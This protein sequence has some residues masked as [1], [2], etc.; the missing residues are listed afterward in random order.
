MKSEEL[1]SFIKAI[2]DAVS[3]RR[4]DDDVALPVFDPATSDNGAETWCNNIA[5]LTEEF[6]WS[7]IATV[8]KAEY[9]F[10]SMSSSSILDIGEKVLFDDSIESIEFHPYTP[11][12]DSF[13]NNDNIHICINRQD[14]ILLP[15]QSQILVEGTVEKGCL[16]VNNGAAFL[17]QDIRYEL[18]GVEIDQAR[19][20]G[21]T[22]TMKG[23][24]SY[25]KEMDHSL[26]TAGWEVGAKKI[27]DKFT[28]T[29]P[30]SH[31]LGFAEDYKKVIMNGKHELI[32]NRASTDVNCL[33]L[34]AVDANTVP[35]PPVPNGE[36]E[37]TR[38]TW[39]MPVIKVS[40]KEKLRLMSYV[41][42]S[43]PVQIVPH[44]G[45]V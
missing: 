22:S 39:R 10:Q 45:A 15:S 7:S 24:V 36:I 33:D 18:N 27:H 4:P 44:V 25:T 16:L 2:A 38:V 5:E 1:K 41:E 34:A 32:L 23:L 43:I 17:F 28:V 21:I 8:A 13:K 20:C 26:Q 11:Y 12:N 9:R 42:R 35:Q 19:N 6:G 14:L 40:D 30:L 29:I 37:I 31:I 3:K